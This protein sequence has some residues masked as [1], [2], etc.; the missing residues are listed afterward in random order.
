MENNLLNSDGLTDWAKVYSYN[1]IYEEDCWK[2][3]CS[4][5]CCNYDIVGKNFKILKKVNEVPLFPGEYHYLKN[6]NKFQEGSTIKILSFTL[7]NNVRI[8]VVLNWCPLNG[9]CSDHGY[10]PVMCRFYPFFP[11]IDYKGKVLSLERSI[12]YDLFWEDIDENM[13][14]SI[15][16]LSIN[17]INSFLGLTANLCRDPNNIFYLIMAGIY[18]KSIYEQMHENKLL[19]NINNAADF[20]KQWEKL[21]ISNKLFDVKKTVYKLTELWDNLNNIYNEEFTIGK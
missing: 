8:P 20:F 11:V 6:N 15:T 14:C 12:P 13:P 7:N 4:S 16:S 17:S 9:N 1:G 21:I 2:S 18:K 5:H 19:N 10:R 3:G